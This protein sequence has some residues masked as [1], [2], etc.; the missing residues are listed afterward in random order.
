MQ[1]KKIVIISRTIFPTNAPRSFRATELAKEFANQGHE[2]Y[3]YAV[4][5]KHN[6]DYFSSKYGIKVRNIG[7]MKF[8]KIDSDGNH[9]HNRFD[10]ILSR[11]FH[12]TLE[13]PDVELMFKIPKIIR[14][15]KNID[16]LI[17]VAIPHPIHWGASLA[18]WKY[19]KNFPKI[20]I[21][22]CGDPYMGNKFHH[23]YFYFKFIEKWFCKNV[24]FITIPFE[25]AKTGYYI[26]FHEKLRIIPQGFSFI[27]IN[28]LEEFIEND[29]L[30]FVY[31]GVFYENI[32]DPCLFLEYISQSKV[33]FRFIIYTRS[34]S[35]LE[36]YLDILGNRLI[37]LDYLSREELLKELAK[38]DFLVNF[39]NGTE[40]QIPSKLI[41]YALAK[42]PILSIKSNVLEKELID[43]FLN[44][45]YES[46]LIVEN[47]DQF[48]IKNVA[49]NFMNLYYEKG[50]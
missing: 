3:L 20:W 17:T 13:F 44:R 30:T 42:R 35:I 38:S 40:N 18:K 45:N 14:N 11:L 46:Q 48:N 24:D 2:V 22:D 6:Y 10:S 47:I 28:I 29:V 39:E 31:A 5:G 49:N 32:R 34:K 4:L 19:K 23:H 43:S 41:D 36:P 33:D 12:K 37:V 26:E 25:G 16:L 27:D 7:R 8:A 15:E 1:R 9:F 50:V 21:A